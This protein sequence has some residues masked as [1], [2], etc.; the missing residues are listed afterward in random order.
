[1]EY[2]EI[3]TVFNMVNYIFTNCEC[4]ASTIVPNAQVHKATWYML[5]Y[6]SVT[7]KRHYMLS[8]SPYIGGLWLGKLR[9]WA[10]PKAELASKGQGKTLVIKYVDKHGKQ[11]WKGSKSL[12]SSEFFVSIIGN[13]SV[14]YMFCELLLFECLPPVLSIFRYW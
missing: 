7:P 10:I 6:G 8:N 9:N 1:M 5:H 2:N 11:R 13:L 14:F 3:Y 12:R 4:G